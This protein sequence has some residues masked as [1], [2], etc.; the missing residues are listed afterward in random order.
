MKVKTIS[1]SRKTMRYICPNLFL[2][3][4]HQRMLKMSA[5][6]GSKTVPSTQEDGSSDGSTTKLSLSLLILLLF[7]TSYS[8]IYSSHWIFC[9]LPYISWHHL[10]SEY[11][12][13]HVLLSFPST[14]DTCIIYIFIPS[15]GRYDFLLLKRVTASLPFSIKIVYDYL[16]NIKRG[17]YKWG[18][19]KRQKVK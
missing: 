2:N 16:F 4:A 19:S 7:A 18:I 10:F 9:S 13:L 8:S 11:G 15:R 6:G 14:E 1:N 5:G 12:I 3:F 17:I